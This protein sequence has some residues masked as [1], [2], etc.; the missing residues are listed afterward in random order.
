MTA[1]VDGSSRDTLRVGGVTLASRLV[2]GTGKYA[3]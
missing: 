3:S 2:V 1:P